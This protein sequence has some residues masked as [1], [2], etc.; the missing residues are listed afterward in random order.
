MVL[1][2]PLP[3]S[4]HTHTSPLD[5]RSAR[6]HLLFWDCALYLSVSLS[7][8]LAISLSRSGSPR[9]PNDKKS[10]CYINCYYS[11]LLGPDSST[12]FPSDGGLTGP[13][14]ANIWVS[15]FDA[16]PATGGSLM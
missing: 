13:E 4:I 15:A 12:K 11:G 7:R 2:P 9:S 3:P 16:C 1:P 5:W 14:I 10:L 8:C 6:A